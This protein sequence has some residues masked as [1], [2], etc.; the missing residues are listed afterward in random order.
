MRAAPTES[1]DIFI[2][3]TCSKPEPCRQVSP[4]IPLR[5]LPLHEL[6]FCRLLSKVSWTNARN[7]RGQGGRGLFQLEQSEE[8]SQR[9][10]NLN[11]IWEDVN[12][13]DM[14]GLSIAG[15]GD[16]VSRDGE[17]GMTE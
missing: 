9:M 17:G 4:L 8:G 5:G 12:P 15:G 11:L 7:H 2:S 13:L 10:L 16:G 6:H 1:P 14:K 3:G